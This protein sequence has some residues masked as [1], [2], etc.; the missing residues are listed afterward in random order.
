[1]RSMKK[2]KTNEK[3]IFR[4]NFPLIAKTTGC[5]ALSTAMLIGT[6]TQTKVGSAHAIE[7]SI[8]EA[9]QQIQP[10]QSQVVQILP[11]QAQMQENLLKTFGN[12][13]LTD[14]HRL[15]LPK[16]SKSI[17]VNFNFKTTLAQQNLFR[18]AIDE[19]N[20]IFAII[21]PAYHFEANFSPTKRDVE[22]IYNINV[23]QICSFQTPTM[24][25]LAT[26]LSQDLTSEI[27]GKELY[28]N[29]IEIA[30][31]SFKDASTLLTVFKHEFMHTLGANDLDDENFASIMQNLSEN[32]YTHLTSND[33]AL[34]ACLF[35]ATTAYTDAEI[36]SYITTYE[37]S[38]AFNWSLSNSALKLEHNFEILSKHLNSREN[39]T[40]L[41]QELEQKY[42][43]SQIATILSQT[44][45]QAPP[46]FSSDLT[47][48][49]LLQPN[50][51][52]SIHKF[53]TFSH[54]TLTVDNFR[55]VDPTKNLSIYHFETQY[56]NIAT[57]KNIFGND[58][59]AYINLG[60]YV[61]QVEYEISKNILVKLSPQAIFK[62]TN[63]SKEEYSQSLKLANNESGY[64]C[65]NNKLENKIEY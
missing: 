62:S 9:K 24:L 32:S 56:S 7:A 27:D 14:G 31:K 8:N 11:S 37:I 12:E 21:N 13:L 59:T 1:M 18:A 22:S 51:N 65:T 42:L 30:E 34:L 41:M 61:L 3:Q 54:Q 64:S 20:N 47:L 63:I 39:L 2:I 15:A 33:V 10:Y 17:K 43:S 16:N 19:F 25:G 46:N 55:D 44:T 53:A 6:A 38:N 26:S 23:E 50:S 40:K 35:K 48:C 58:T 45:S 49:E 4:I 5:L 29:K 57:Y 60:E 36:E 28:S 52:A